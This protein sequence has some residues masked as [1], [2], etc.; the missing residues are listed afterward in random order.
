MMNASE[1]NLTQA[2][3]ETLLEYAHDSGNWGYMPYVSCGNVTC[4]KE[5][6]GNLSD[7]VKQGLV[8]IHDSGTREAY[9][10]FTLCG[11]ALAKAHGCEDVE[12]V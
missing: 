3:L 10:K 9:I 11:V 12:A 7:L 4:T 5:M 6:R 1:I 2:S 8:V